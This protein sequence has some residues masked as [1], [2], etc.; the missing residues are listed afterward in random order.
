MNCIYLNVL[1]GGI[2]HWVQ[3]CI[4]KKTN[5]LK[6]WINWQ[7]RFF[8]AYIHTSAVWGRNL[9]PFC[10][11][12]GTTS[13]C[14]TIPTYTTFTPLNCYVLVWLFFLLPKAVV[15]KCVQLLL[16]AWLI[17]W[18]ERKRRFLVLCSLLE[19]SFRL[20]IISVFLGMPLT[21]NLCLWCG[22]GLCRWSFF[23]VF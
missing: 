14:S 23:S 2:L 18:M 1:K 5:D 10:V 15:V 7:T 16:W 6:H 9:L 3:S 4:K 17:A 20:S 22:T 11:M 19:M 21:L 12:M 8:L 13:S